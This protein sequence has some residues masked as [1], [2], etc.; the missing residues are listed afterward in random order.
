MHR[1]R[2]GVRD[3][4]R[5]DA[6][7]PAA[8]AQLRSADAPRRGLCGLHDRVLSRPAAAAE[9]LLV[10][11]P[12]VLPSVPRVYEKVHTAS[13]AQFERDRRLKRRIVDWS[14]RVGGA[15][16]SCA[17]AGA[18]RPA[19]PRAAAPAR[20]PARLRE[21]AR[22]GSAAAAVAISGGAP[23]AKEIAEFFDALGITILEG[24][25]LT[26]CTSAATVNRPDRL[27]ARHGRAARCPGA[28]LRARRRRRA[29]HPQPDGLRRLP[30]GRRGDARGARRRRLAPLRRR[31][32][33]RRRRL[34]ARSPTARR[35]SS[36]PRAARTS[37]RR[38]SRTISRRAARS[39]RRSSSATG[40]RSS[41]R[42]S[43]STPKRARPSSDGE[44]QARVQ[45]IV[46]DVNR[47]RSRYE[48][49]K[50]FAILPRDFSMEEGE[51]T[52]TLKLKRRVV[53]EHFARRDRASS[54][55]ASPGC[56]GRR[57]SSTRRSR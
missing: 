1:S 15:S 54:T 40:G 47:D 24:Y 57:R 53:L 48:Q 18:S 55:R 25:G 4:R 11:R 27:P 21:G 50:R 30:Q 35:T 36:S 26:E 33:D 6:P 2:P 39:R 7:L 32:R 46:D 20:R 51:V 34:R 19:G 8:R 56:G 38:T 37:R 28:E 17:R 44:Q 49:I 41:R 9:A 3:R 29:L 13:P 5:P 42:S 22:A 12:T 23:L 14:L 10:V 43:R 16:A 52:P 31:R 45:E